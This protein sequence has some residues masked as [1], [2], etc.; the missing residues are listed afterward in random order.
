MEKRSRATHELLRIG[1]R[2]TEMTSAPLWV[3]QVQGEAMPTQAGRTSIVKVQL[4][5]CISGA[6]LAESL[7]HL[8]YIS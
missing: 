6:V 1:H 5:F 7:R 4:C 8:A 3:V 2:N